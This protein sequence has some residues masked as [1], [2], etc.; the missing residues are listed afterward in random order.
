[1][2]HNRKYIAGKIFIT[3]IS[4]FL[5]IGFNA[6]LDNT[7]EKIIEEEKKAEEKKVGYRQDNEESINSLDHFFPVSVTW[8]P[9]E[10]IFQ[11]IEDDNLKSGNQPAQP[12]QGVE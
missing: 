9:Q 6:Y 1:M 2:D 12:A 7:Y 4:L 11:G 10:V 5:I 3:I 8:D